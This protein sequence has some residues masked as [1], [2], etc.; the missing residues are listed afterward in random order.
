MPEALWANPDHRIDFA[1]MPNARYAAQRHGNGN[2]L[3]AECDQ[4]VM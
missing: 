2:A 4:A 3:E 1:W